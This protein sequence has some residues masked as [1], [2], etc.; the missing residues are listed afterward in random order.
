MIRAQTSNDQ[1][2]LVQ[3]KRMALEAIRKLATTAEFFK[4]GETKLTE[5]T[6]RLGR[7]QR[8]LDRMTDGGKEMSLKTVTSLCSRLQRSLVELRDVEVSLA[9]VEKWYRQRPEDSDK[10]EREDADEASDREEGE[11]DDAGGEDD[12]GIVYTGMLVQQPK[13]LGAMGERGGG[14]NDSMKIA[15]PAKRGRPDEEEEPVTPVRPYKQPYIAG[16]SFNSAGPTFD[17]T[18]RALRGDHSD[19]IPIER[20]K[21]S[22]AEYTTLSRAKKERERTLPEKHE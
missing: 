7:V 11:L 10:K 20:R 18:P 22:L 17:E 8:D 19:A 5:A 21:V 2:W 13:R 16:T 9:R 3:A 12:G 14:V 6:E 1:L 4:I 15:V